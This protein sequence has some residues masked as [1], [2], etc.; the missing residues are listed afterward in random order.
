MNSLSILIP[1]YNDRCVALVTALH[2]QAESLAVDYEVIV[3]DDGSTDADVVADNRRVNELPH[4]RMIESPHNQGRAAIRNLLAQEARHEWLLFIDSD[5]QVCRPD[6]L[7]HY[8]TACQ[9]ADV[10]DGGVEIAPLQPGNL[11]SLY[12]KVSE[13][14]HVVERRRQSPYQD[15]HTAN[16]LIRRS[17]ML[18]HPFD[19]RFRRYGYEDVLLGKQLEQDGI[20]ILHVDNPLLFGTFETNAAFVSKTEEGLRTLYQFRDDLQGY[21]L[22]LV[23]ARRLAPI[24]PLVRLWHR[25]FAKVERRHLTGQHP[26]IFV[27]HLYRLGYFL[28][29]F[30]DDA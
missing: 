12:E 30:R 7:Q 29:L 28:T 15:F 18:A 19:L 17:L 25:I 14:Q 4:C 10:V 22:M 9:E 6:Y 13:Q 11:R 2:Q 8:L 23:H 26:T 20:A 21:S 16:F 3:A 5:M 24:A 27:F 1:T